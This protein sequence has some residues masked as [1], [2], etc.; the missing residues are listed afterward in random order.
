MSRPQLLFIT[1]KGGAGKTTIAAALGVHAAEEG[2]R[3]LV[4]EFTAD[5]GLAALFGTHAPHAAP[6]PLAPGLDGVRVESR[7]L[8]EAY[9]TRLLRIPFLA[10]RLLESSTFNAVTAAAPGVNEFLVLEHLL[11]WLEPG[12]AARRHRYDLII[13]DSPATGHALRLLR[14]PQQILT[15]VPSGPIG[16]TA[17]QLFSLLADHERTQVCLVAL[18]DE[19]VINETIEAHA[20]LADNLGLRLT[21]PVLNRVFPR[22]FTSRDART[23]TTLISAHPNDPV[24]LAARLQLSARH[25]AD[26]HLRRLRR[27]FGVLPLSVPQI[28]SDR[29]DL[30]DLHHMGAMLS[31]SLFHEPHPHDRH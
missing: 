15:M 22:R 9:F 17:H 31:R 29:I 14:T 6:T 20:A 12:R 18:P 1:G 28:C 27:A 5:R 30:R 10:H 2:S 26:R 3:V 23:I 8:V 4:V 13:V 25:D 7:A 11:Q 24:L 19:M 21:R 16:A